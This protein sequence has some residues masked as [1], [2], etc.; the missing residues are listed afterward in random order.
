MRIGAPPEI[1][2]IRLVDENEPASVRWEAK[3]G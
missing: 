1:V 2:L 3:K